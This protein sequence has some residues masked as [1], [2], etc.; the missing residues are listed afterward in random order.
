MIPL[1]LV[2]KIQNLASK[3]NREICG[4]VDNLFNLYPIKNVAKASNE[5]ILDKFEYLRLLNTL[6]QQNRHVIVIF[7]SHLDGD[8]TPSKCDL[9]A[10]K[11]LKIPY[12]IVSKNKYHLELVK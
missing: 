5:F 11:R 7:H 8:I 9:E 12:L 2:V 10:V 1:D 4:A 6:K 3:S